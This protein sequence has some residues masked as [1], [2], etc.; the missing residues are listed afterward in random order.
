MTTH[1]CSFVEGEGDFQ[2]GYAIR[3]L[4]LTYIVG[5]LGKRGKNRKT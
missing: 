1:S 5:N 2:K 3:E 4:I